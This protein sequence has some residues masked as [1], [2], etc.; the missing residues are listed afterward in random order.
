MNASQPGLP[1][2]ESLAVVVFANETVCKA[3]TWPQNAPDTN[4][5]E[6]HEMCYRFLFDGV[7]L[8]SEA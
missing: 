6:L 4:V 7:M 2:T 8:A 5:V 3:S 1:R